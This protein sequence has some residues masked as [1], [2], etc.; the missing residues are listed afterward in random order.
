[1]ITVALADVEFFAYHGFYPEEQVLGT[2]FFIDISVNFISAKAFNDDKIGNTVNYETLYS[3]IKA[4]ME[5]PRQLIETVVQG[6]IDKT[7]AKFPFIDSAQ[8]TLKKMHPALGGP[9]KHSAVT[10]SY[11]NN[12]N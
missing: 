1:M 11:H 8:V 5:H 2:H 7:V 12:Q 6:I 10:L 9:V 4:E 3:I